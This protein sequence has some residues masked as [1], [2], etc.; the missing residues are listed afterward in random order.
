MFAWMR[1]QLLVWAP[2]VFRAATSGSRNPAQWLIDW[3]RGDNRGDSGISVTGESAMSY[4]P[5]WYAVTKITGHIAT[6]PLVCH[7]RLGERRKRRATNHPAYRLLKRKPNRMMT[8]CTFK[9]IL[10]YHALIHG[11]GRAII[12]RNN[13]GEPVELIPMLP[14]RTN[15]CIIDGEK[16]HIT[17]ILMDKATDRWTPRKFRDE[18]VLHIIGLGFD[19]IQGYPLYEVAKNSIGLGLAAEKASNRHFRKDAVPNLLLEVPDGVLPD[20][21]EAEDFL[22]KFRA[23]HEGLDAESKTAM[24]RFGIKANPLANTQRDG[25]WIEQRMLQRQ[26]AALWF[27]LESI[28]GDDK[29]VSYNSLEQKNMAYLS[30]CLARWMSKWEEECEEKLLRESE[31]AAD[32]HF[33]KFNAGAL[34]RADYKT[35]LEALQIGVSSTI[36]SPN[37]A[38]DRIDLDEREGGDTYANPNTMSGSDPPRASGLAARAVEARLRELLDVE[39]ARVTA[40]AQSPGRFLARLDKFYAGWRDTQARVVG[41][42]LDDEA[43]ASQLADAWCEA[44]RGQL[45]AAAG[46]A[47]E[48]TLADQVAIAIAAW[49][50]RVKDLTA[51]VV[52][53][54][55]AAA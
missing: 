45:L 34:L 22:K 38:R 35:T 53:G 24:L 13:R 32:S 21:K 5:V 54:E 40:A 18:N 27:L 12:V 52:S 17:E 49:P 55:T 14:D 46:D 30:N 20:D 47:T 19:G 16:W 37:E 29:S 26:D 41:R 6:M 48:E 7:Q 33:F 31:K 43:R 50:E 15:T 9:E 2:T 36:I 3:I 8:A 4:A 1:R 39:T 44:S 23:M 51:V 25:Q 42:L 28:L 10:Q 11:N